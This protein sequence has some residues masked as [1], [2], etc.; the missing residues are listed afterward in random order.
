MK[1]TIES[2]GR[3]HSTEFLNDDVSI[4]DYI[5]T[6]YALLIAAT[7]HHHTIINGFK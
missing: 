6:F 7:F 3:T 4:G 1:I 5:D 2:Y